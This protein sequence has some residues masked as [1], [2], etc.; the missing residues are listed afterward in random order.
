MHQSKGIQ[1]HLF[2]REISYHGRII[3]STGYTADPKN[4]VTTSSKLKKK[5]SSITELRSILGLMG[6]VRKLIPD[7]SQ[8]VSLLYQILN[9]TKS[10]Q[11]HSKE[12]ID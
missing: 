5:P 3:S 4:I 1:I 7:F 11:R 9:D 6:Y 10:K 12:P 2:K 8:I